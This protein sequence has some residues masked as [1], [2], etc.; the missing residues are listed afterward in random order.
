MVARTAYLNQSKLG[1][2]EYRCCLP[3]RG[4]PAFGRQQEYK[5]FLETTEHPVDF[6]RWEKMM[7]LRLRLSW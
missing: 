2:Y 1:F 4:R 6:Q 7:I 5:K 3:K